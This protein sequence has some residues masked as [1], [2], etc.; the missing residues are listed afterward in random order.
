VD[1]VR[2]TVFSTV[3]VVVLVV[4]V[5]GVRRSFVCCSDPVVE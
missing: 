1:D 5:P 3:E 2:V 4:D